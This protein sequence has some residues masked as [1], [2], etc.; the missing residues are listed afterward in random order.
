ML[1]TIIALYSVY[2]SARKLKFLETLQYELGF[3]QVVFSISSRRVEISFNGCENQ[4]KEIHVLFVISEPY[5]TGQ[6]KSLAKN[7]SNVFAEL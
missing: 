4:S 6:S 5:N 1:L 7:K 3:C 2:L